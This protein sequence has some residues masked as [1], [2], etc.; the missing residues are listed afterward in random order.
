MVLRQN[1]TRN[2][3]N[4]VALDFE[5]GMAEERQVE[6]L[7]PDL[8]VDAIQ[9]DTQLFEVILCKVMLFICEYLTVRGS[10][11]AYF[12]I[13]SVREI[14]HKLKTFPLKLGIIKEALCYA[15]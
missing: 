2:L 6:P 9:A 11:V 15:R 4:T 5:L 12:F 8:E 3:T 1:T 7:A 10:F 13:L 14:F